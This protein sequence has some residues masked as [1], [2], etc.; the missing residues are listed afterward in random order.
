MRHCANSAIL[1]RRATAS[2][3]LAPLKE[4]IPVASNSDDSA[5]IHGSGYGKAINHLAVN[6]LAVV[7]VVGLVVLGANL[8]IAEQSKRQVL[9][10]PSP[11]K[12]APEVTPAITRQQS[13]LPL[14]ALPAQKVSRLQRPQN[15][16]A[17]KRPYWHRPCRRQG[18]YAQATSPWHRDSHSKCKVR[19]LAHEC[20]GAGENQS[21]GSAFRAICIRLDG[22]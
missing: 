15:R 5:V 6:F 20:G 18:Q 14:F 7:V 3:A 16:H 12:T 13:S 22:A 1:A 17:G 10:D 4:Q 9:L 21:A 8:P 11:A 2:R 19:V